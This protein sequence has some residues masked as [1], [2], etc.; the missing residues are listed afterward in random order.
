MHEGVNAFNLVEL[1]MLIFPFC[2]FLLF[3]FVLLSLYGERSIF[4]KPRKL[5]E[6]Y[7]L[8]V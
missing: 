2:C 6:Y 8:D 1:T 7:S 4:I 5:H 3:S